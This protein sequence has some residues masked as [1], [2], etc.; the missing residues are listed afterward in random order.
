MSRR[1]EC[2]PG[3]A[4]NRGPDGPARA[5]SRS[6]RAC[7][8]HTNPEM[9]FRSARRA[10]ECYTLCMHYD[11]R[12]P[13][14]Q[15]RDMPEQVYEALSERARAR[16][17]SLAQQAVVELSKP[18]DAGPGLRRRELVSRLRERFSEGRRRGALSN[19]VKLV[20]EDRTR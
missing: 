13:S 4:S 2:E 11:D 16:R 3:R 20:R 10:T 12:M 15:I 19:P 6:R 7:V 9:P 8:R 5:R 17:R 1:V 14:L 18:H